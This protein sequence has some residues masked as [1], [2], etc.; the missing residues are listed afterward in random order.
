MS[1]KWYQPKD[2]IL[3]GNIHGK[4]E[5]LIPILEATVSGK[6]VLDIGCNAGLV[7]LISKKLGA[8]KV[9]GI[10]K[11]DQAIEQAKMGVQ[12]WGKKGLLKDEKNI[13]FVSG[14]IS[15]NLN[16]VRES[17]FLIMIR[18]IYHLRE[19]I[20]DIMNIVKNKK[21]MVILVQGNLARKSK[22]KQEKTPYGNKLALASSIS[23]F[24]K[25]YNFDTFIIPGEIV[26]A[27]H[28]KSNLNFKKIK[29]YKNKK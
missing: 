17:N 1:E 2:S 10:D 16:L 21:D 24:L 20:L 3:E 28:K 26:I 9:V 27:K 11:R 12:S 18:S 6:N 13:S 19:N 14:N 4:Y 25:S 7:S 15:D 8:K 5:I 29:Y 22:Q 23:S